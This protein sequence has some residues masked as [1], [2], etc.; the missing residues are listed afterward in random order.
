MAL[1]NSEIPSGMVEQGFFCKPSAENSV[2]TKRQL[3]ISRATVY[4]LSPP[5]AWGDSGS[6]RFTV[7]CPT[8]A[9]DPHI[10]SHLPACFFVVGSKKMTSNIK[11]RATNKHDKGNKEKI[12]VR[13]LVQLFPN[14][15]GYLG[16]NR[17]V[18]G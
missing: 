18:K 12:A 4:A 13:R 3:S 1:L 11:H 9:K 5:C 16:L 17:R 6:F 8:N 10:S 2:Q 15:L 7:M 14:I